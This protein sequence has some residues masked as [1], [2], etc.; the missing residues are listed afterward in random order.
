MPHALQRHSTNARSYDASQLQM[1]PSRHAWTIPG[2][3]PCLE[4][5]KAS[6]A[7]MA[8]NQQQLP[9]LMV[10]IIDPTTAVLG[11]VDINVDVHV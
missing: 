2:Y 7:S 4:H 5:A 11:Q 9:E 1:L 6:R 10:P 3:T 8:L